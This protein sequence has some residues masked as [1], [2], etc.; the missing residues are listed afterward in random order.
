[1]YRGPEVGPME[2]CKIGMKSNSSEDEVV[3]IE[4]IGSLQA[5][6]DLRWKNWFIDHDHTEN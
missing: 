1:M 2:I 4:T 3:T 5:N 6:H